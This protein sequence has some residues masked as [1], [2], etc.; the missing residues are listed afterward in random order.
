MVV[1][2]IPCLNYHIVALGY[3]VVLVGHIDT[4]DDHK[5]LILD[6]HLIFFFNNGK[7]NVPTIKT[8]QIAE[9]IINPIPIYFPAP[10][11]GKILCIPEKN[12]S[13]ID[14][15]SVLLV[16]SFDTFPE[17]SLVTSLIHYYLIYLILCHLMIF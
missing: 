15:V 2:H 1:G 10:A 13:I 17:L 14:F 8:R 4:L 6:Y 9:M 3:I 7:I 12:S 11:H 5:R 16:T